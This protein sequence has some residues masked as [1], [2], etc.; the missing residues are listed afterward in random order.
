MVAALLAAAA[1]VVTLHVA[2]VSHTS[3]VVGTFVRGTRCLAALFY[4]TSA[5]LAL[6]VV[7]VHDGSV[8]VRAGHGVA[9]LSFGMAVVP[10]VAVCRCRWTKWGTTGLRC[11]GKVLEATG[12]GDESVQ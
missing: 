11:L 4:S 9:V 2:S 3:V 12:P 5:V 7:G 6:H 10:V 1:G 8:A